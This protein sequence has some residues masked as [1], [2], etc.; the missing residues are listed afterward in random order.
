VLRAHF[1][2]V[3]LWVGSFLIQLLDTVLYTHQNCMRIITVL[4]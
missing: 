1:F 4:P 2:L 3:V